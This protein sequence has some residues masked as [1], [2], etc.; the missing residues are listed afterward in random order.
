M[1]FLL[2]QIRLEGSAG[3][4]TAAKTT[5]LGPQIFVG[6]ALVIKVSKTV[7]LVVNILKEFLERVKDAP[8][9]FLL[10]LFG[11][12]SVAKRAKNPMRIVLLVG[13]F[14]KC[15][16][17]AIVRIATSKEMWKRVH[18]ANSSEKFLHHHWKW[19]RRR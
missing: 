9:D 12:V 3:I 14:P 13:K 1:E 2:L 17:A 18:S 11:N 6:N 10:N 7:E 4:A 16:N 15:G 8:M 5:T 19:Q